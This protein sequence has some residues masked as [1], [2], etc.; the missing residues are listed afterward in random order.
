MI[1][2]CLP[3]QMPVQLMRY[4]IYFVYNAKACVTCM[5]YNDDVFMMNNL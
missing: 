2:M 1:M 5:C 3:K 4:I